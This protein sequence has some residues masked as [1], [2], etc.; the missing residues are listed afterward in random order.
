MQTAKNK[1]LEKWWLMLIQA[2]LLI[3]TGAVFVIRLDHKPE[4]YQ[5]WISV[6][7]LLF[8][9]LSVL[10]YFWASPFDKSGWEL[11]IGILSLAGGLILLISDRPEQGF[12][13]WFFSILL[14][15]QAFLYTNTYWDL[16]HEA[17]FWWMI[18][19]LFGYTLFLMYGII[20]AETFLGQ[21]VL[22]LAGLQY[23]FCGIITMFFVFVTR[24]M[25]IEFNK[26]ISFF[27]LGNPIL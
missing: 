26:P 15:L 11:S 7:S 14:F 27:R 3:F 22:L 2:L 21:S 1:Y 6:V 12:S 9:A 13:P 5:T 18:F 20:S 10:A 8:G 4:D 19:P 23:I 25:Q 17:R 24:R 16:R